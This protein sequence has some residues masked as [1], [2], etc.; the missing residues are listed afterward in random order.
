MGQHRALRPP[1][2]AGGV[3]DHRRVLLAHRRPWRR[4]YG[5]EEIGDRLAARRNTADA[6][7][8]RERRRRIGWRQLPGEPGLE[9]Q[10]GGTTIVQQI[11]QL[12]LELTDI[13]WNRDRAQ[14]DTGEDEDQKL[15][16]IPEEQSDA[17]PGLDPAP[18]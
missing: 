15:R 11:A 3:E 1:G 14:T 18:R 12:R 4:G 16:A 10:S 5:P 8:E 9:H 7:A 13:E 6:N 2:G 17:V